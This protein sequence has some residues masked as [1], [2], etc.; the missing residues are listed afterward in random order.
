MMGYFRSMA[1]IRIY[2]GLDYC[3]S[4]L[5]FFVFCFILFLGILRYAHY[6]WFQN[7]SSTLYCNFRRRLRNASCKDVP[8]GCSHQTNQARI[9][10]KSDTKSP[11]GLYF[12]LAQF[13]LKGF[14]S[15]DS[16]KESLKFCQ[17]AATVYHLPLLKEMADWNTRRK[18]LTSL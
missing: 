5:T 12:N 1:E 13:Y 15:F 3:F 18:Q 2:V 17:V 7:S 4:L 14:A 6:R 8:I 11:R 9:Y 10:L 16:T